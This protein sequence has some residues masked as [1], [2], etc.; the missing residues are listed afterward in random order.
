MSK[1]SHHTVRSSLPYRYIIRATS[2]FQSLVAQW[3]RNA[4]PE[5]SG[6]AG[7]GGEG[8]ARDAR[9]A[10]RHS[11]RMSRH[12]VWPEGQTRASESPLTRRT[13]ERAMKGRVPENTFAA[14]P[15]AE[16]TTSHERE[17]PENTFAALPH[18]ERPTNE[19]PLT[20]RTSDVSIRRPFSF[21]DRT[22]S[23]WCLA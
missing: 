20:G 3:R 19:S 6:A 11:V 8:V 9:M 12:E 10:K 13:D 1:A 22:P 16:R 14:L 15:H 5:P 17:G 7:W 2:A 21:N 4:A 23:V 18:A